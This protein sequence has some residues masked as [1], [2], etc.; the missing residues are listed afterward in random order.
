MSTHYAPWGDDA[1]DPYI[2]R[3]IN[4]GRLRIARYVPGAGHNGGDLFSAWIDPS[5]PHYA[6]AKREADDE[7]DT[8]RA[9]SAAI[10]KKATP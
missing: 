6:H 5:H 8:R 10:A 3:W 7:R 9:I 2:Y 4:V 1:R